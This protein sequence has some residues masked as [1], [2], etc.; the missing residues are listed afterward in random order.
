MTDDDVK[1][2]ETVSP[3]GLRERAKIMRG[4][5]D[6]SCARHLE[7]AADRIEG[8]ETWQRANLEVRDLD[9]SHIIKLETA[10]NAF[11][12]AYGSQESSTGALDKAFALAKAAIH[13]D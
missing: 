10:S 12:L 3:E 8:L 7:L 11:I 13:E 9:T 4:S 5:M 1:I 6:E 2:P